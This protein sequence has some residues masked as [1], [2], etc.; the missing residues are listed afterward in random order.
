MLRAYLDRS[1]A[2]KYGAVAVARWLLSVDHLQNEVIGSLATMDNAIATG[3][4][5]ALETGA[6]EEVGF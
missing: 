3:P 2:P 1:E 5:G 4:L 6:G